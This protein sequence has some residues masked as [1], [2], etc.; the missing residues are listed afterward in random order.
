[1]GNNCNP[2]YV[3]LTG[4]A[5][6]FNRHVPL[7]IQPYYKSNR[8]ILCL[9]T[10]RRDLAIRSAKPIAQRLEDYWLSLRL[11][12]I[13][14]PALHLLRD[15]PLSP[16]QS[17]WMQL[18]EALDFYLRL[19]GAG[20]DKV[21]K[22]GAERD[23]QSVVDVLG[24][25][26]LDEYASSDA[27]NFRGY[28]LKKGLTTNSVKRNFATIRSVIN[29][30]IQEHGLDCKNAFSKV[31]LPDLDD[32]KRRKPIPIEDI[33]QIQQECRQADDEARWLVVL[34]SDTGMRLSEATGLHI[35]DIKLD[36]E[37]PFIDLKPHSWR[38]LKTKGS[39]KGRYH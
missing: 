36:C 27:A 4:N 5:Y 14:I 3:F 25:R 32:A 34:I 21:F 22:R 7:D 33:R 29:L 30:S 39:H 26:P 17:S 9:K 24:D 16:S 37:I 12:M 20:K 15:K 31:F 10:S 23:I 18:T 11:S 19:K 8:I 35:D 38:T 13:D 28:L 1:M 2:S 6:Y